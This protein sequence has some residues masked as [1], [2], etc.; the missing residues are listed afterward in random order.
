MLFGVRI[1]SV[2][3]A[4]AV[5]LLE[6][7]SGV[8]KGPLWWVLPGA[9]VLALLTAVSLIDPIN[10]NVAPQPKGGFAVFVQWVLIIVMALAVAWFSNY[11]GRELIPEL[12]KNPMPQN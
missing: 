10:Q 7:Y 8:I 4:F 5:V 1:L 3:T 12:V 9:L 2:L 6:V 11:F